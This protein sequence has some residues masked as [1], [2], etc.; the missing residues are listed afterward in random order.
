MDCGVG[1]FGDDFGGVVD[2]FFDWGSVVVG[3]TLVVDRVGYCFV[4]FGL[5]IILVC[6]D[7]ELVLCV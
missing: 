2:W 7:Y 4:V 3:V 5:C 6:G 1:Y